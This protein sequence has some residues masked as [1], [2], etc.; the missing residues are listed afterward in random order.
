MHCK[1]VFKY[2]LEATKLHD[3]ECL[4]SVKSR[5]TICLTINYQAFTIIMCFIYQKILKGQFCPLPVTGF[6]YD[7]LAILGVRQ[8]SYTHCYGYDCAILPSF[9]SIYYNNDMSDKGKI[10]LRRA[11]LGRPAHLTELKLAV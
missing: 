11:V 1:L 9:Y 6:Y 3:L 8:H 7:W 5:I 4:Q 2:Y 10:A